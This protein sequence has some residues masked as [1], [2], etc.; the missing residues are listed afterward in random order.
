MKR[1]L[2]LLLLLLPYLIYGVYSF[3]QTDPNLVLTSNSMYWN[4][5]QMMWQIGYHQRQLSGIL[6]SVIMIFFLVSYGLALKYLKIGEKWKLFALLSAVFLL[7]YPALSHDIFNYMFNAKMLLVYHMNPHVHIAL[8]FPQ[9][10][11]TRFM[12]NT[13]TA[14]PYGYGWTILSLIPSIIGMQKFTFT[15]LLYRMFMYAG[16]TLFMY[17]QVSVAQVLKE[18]KY[19]QNIWIF[20]SIL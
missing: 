10:L 2:L 4:F 19:L 15:L 1:K 17:F 7:V 8:E 6:F 12:H 13:N 14:A 5:Q 20:S 18:K 11:W 16:F 3:T 9:D